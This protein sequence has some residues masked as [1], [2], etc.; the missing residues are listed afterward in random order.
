[1]SFFRGVSVE[2]NH[3]LN[4]QKAK[5]R[6]IDGKRVL[7]KL[8]IPRRKLIR[9]LGTQ[10]KGVPKDGHGLCAETHGPKGRPLGP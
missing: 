4:L 3:S 9:H 5:K 8:N 6:D 10:E 2:R 7:Y 1:V